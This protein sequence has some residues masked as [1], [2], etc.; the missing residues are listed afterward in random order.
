ML[1]CSENRVSHQIN[2]RK[3]ELAESAGTPFAD[4]LPAEQIKGVLAECDVVFR[5]RVFDPVV[6]LWAFLSQVMSQDHSCREAVARVLAQR[7]FSGKKPCSPQTGSYCQARQRLPKEVL[8][9]LVRQTGR[10]LQQSADM[11]WLWKGRHVKIGDGTTVSMPDTRANQKAFPQSSGQKA[12][13]G[14]P[15]ARLVVI[16]SLAC[17]AALEVAVGPCRGKKTGE[18][19]LFRGI[20]DSLNE[21]DVL[22]GDRLFDSYHDIGL[23][24]QRKVDVVFRMNQT[25]H[26]DFRRGRLLGCGDHVVTWKKP[27]FD[28]NRFDR[29]TYDALPETMLMREVRFQVQVDGFRTDTIVL[30]TTLTDAE[31]YPAEEVAELYLKRWHCELDLNSLKTTLQMGKLRCKTPDMVRKEILAHLLAYNLIRTVMAEAARKHDVI[32]R[33]LSFKGALQTVAS[34]AP[35]LAFCVTDHR[36]L[37]VS[38]LLRAIASHRVG[39]RPNRIEPRAIKRRQTKYPYLT[40]PRNQAKKLLTA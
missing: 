29:A 30:V 23:L 28:S 10:Q 27:R 14:F 32:P 33:H 22:L 39:N 2:Y 35:A 26:C 21:G 18:N 16:F 36:D 6:T 24:K 37:Q 9:K 11:R 5:K 17:G 4:L 20:M 3:C 13:L 38:A 12:G 40:V 25:R 31:Q 15:M 34:F 1:Y 8:A 7:A 19:T